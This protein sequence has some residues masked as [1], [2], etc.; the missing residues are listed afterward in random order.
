MS[1]I[2][3]L[4]LPKT[5]YSTK[6]I[7]RWLWKAWKGNRLQACL[8]AAIG[9]LGVGVS[10]ASVWAVQRA[11]DVASHDLEG[12]IYVAVIVMGLLILCDFAL[13]VA[14]VWIRNIL[15][16]KAQNRM[17]QQLL[18][19][20]L[21]SQWK[22]KETHHSGDV[23]NRLEFDVSNVV[24]FLTEVIPNSLS[25]L[26]L[27]LGAFGYLL[28]MDWRLAFIIT[29]MIPVFVIFSKLYIRQMRSLTSEV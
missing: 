1:L 21:R 25:T 5:K 2:D 11:I 20:I 4:K 24:N 10:L 17:Q 26:A 29:F 3:Y 6:E 14:S 7:L 23:L 15:G 12:N 9:L 27:F 16:I 18:D 28:S 8:N 13:N 19:R 22:G